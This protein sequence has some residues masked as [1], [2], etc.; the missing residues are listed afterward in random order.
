MVLLELTKHIFQIEIFIRFIMCTYTFGIIL[1]IGSLTSWRLEVYIWKWYFWFSFLFKLF[2]FSLEFIFFL[3]LSWL[4]L[5]L[6]LLNRFN[7]WLILC[8]ILLLWFHSWWR[9][10]FLLI[11]FSRRLHIALIL[12]ARLRKSPL[13]HLINLFKCRLVL[14]CLTCGVLLYLL[15]MLIQ[16]L[17]ACLTL[18]PFVLLTRTYVTHAA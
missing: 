5:F 14:I 9:S 1:E 12:L 8:L 4:I 11:S 7:W 16:Y 10:T 6:I 13:I 3:N 17:L 18:Y 15:L 2:R